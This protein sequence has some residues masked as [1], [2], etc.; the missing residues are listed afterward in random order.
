MKII[1]KKF[2]FKNEENNSNPNFKEKIQFKS[3]IKTIFKRSFIIFSSIYIFTKALK[4]KKKKNFD[5]NKFVLKDEE[6]QSLNSYKFIQKNEKL[7][8]SNPENNK[9]K[10]QEKI[11][12]IGDDSI[13]YHLA[14]YLSKDYF[15][16]IILI[17]FQKTQ[18]KKFNEKLEIFNLNYMPKFNIIENYSFLL[19][20]F[21]SINNFFWL[22]NFM[23]LSWKGNQLRNKFWNYFSV[24]NELNLK[25]KD[26]SNKGDR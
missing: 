15:K 5:E 26:K 10:M 16:D 22:L 21:N 7:F 19:V 14:L 1:K 4:M 6:I 9:N 18:E 25:I 23:T 20:F 24:E 12:V 11:V 3:K 13:S 2:K 17:N 8:V